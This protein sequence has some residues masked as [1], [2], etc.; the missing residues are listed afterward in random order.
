MDLSIVATNEPKDNAGTDHSERP[1]LLSWDVENQ[2][3]RLRLSHDAASD[4]FVSLADALGIELE[5][6]FEGDEEE[7]TEPPPPPPPPP[8]KKIGV[9]KKK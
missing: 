8:K 5:L 9:T 3:R 4:L 1:I 2:P 6:E 7:A